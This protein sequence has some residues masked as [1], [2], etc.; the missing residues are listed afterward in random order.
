MKR[1]SLFG[2]KLMQN[3]FKLH[4]KMTIFCAPVQRLYPNWFSLDERERKGEKNEEKM[5]YGS[6]NAQ[7]NVCKSTKLIVFSCASCKGRSNLMKCQEKL[8]KCQMI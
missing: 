5:Q 4:A 3:A 2:R 6:L 1:T 7:K 8:S